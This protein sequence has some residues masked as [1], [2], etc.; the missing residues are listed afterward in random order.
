MT[1]LRSTENTNAGLLLRG[2][3]FFVTTPQSNSAAQ[4]SHF[5]F[6]IFAVTLPLPRRDFFQ[7]QRVAVHEPESLMQTATRAVLSPDGMCLSIH[8]RNLAYAG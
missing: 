5:L 8:V 1:T 3:E 7:G 6:L 2:A 4:C